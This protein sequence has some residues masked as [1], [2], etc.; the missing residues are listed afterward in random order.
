MQIEISE[1]CQSSLADIVEIRQM[2]SE[3]E[4]AG[5]CV[6]NSGRFS[7]LLDRLASCE[8]QL[9]RRVVSENTGVY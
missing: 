1:G 7:Y 6:E 2:L 9:G 8:R 5:V 3:I 4:D